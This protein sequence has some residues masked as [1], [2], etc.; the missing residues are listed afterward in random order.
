MLN[1]GTTSAT[2]T[3]RFAGRP[4]GGTRILRVIQ[5]L[6]FT[7]LV[8]S[9]LILWLVAGLGNDGGPARKEG[10]LPGVMS[11]RTAGASD[12]RRKPRGGVIEITIG[13]DLCHS[14]RLTKGLG[15]TA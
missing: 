15:F 11:V 2:E 7:W 3:T 1:R 10:R 6:A 14:A 4:I 12:F 5:A 13:R 9:A 8:L